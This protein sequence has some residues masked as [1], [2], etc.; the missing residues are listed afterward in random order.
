MKLHAKIVEVIEEYLGDRID[1]HD[2]AVE[3]CKS[4]LKNI[5]LDYVDELELKNLLSLVVVHKGDNP[6]KVFTGEVASVFISNNPNQIRK[7]KSDPELFPARNK[8][9]RKYF[10]EICEACLKIDSGVNF[11]YNKNGISIKKGRRT[12][13][14]LDNTFL[15]NDEELV[16]TLLLYGAD[17]LEDVEKRLPYKVVNVRTV[18]IRSPKDPIPYVSNVPHD[19]IIEILNTTYLGIGNEDDYK[20]VDKGE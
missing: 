9:H 11:S 3:A 7:G 19:E 2:E 13:V 8:N 17:D 12:K 20:K 1:E 5:G 4:Y 18:S 14:R 10:D 6:T 16:S 15:L